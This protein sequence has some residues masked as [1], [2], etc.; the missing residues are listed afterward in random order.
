ME[1]FTKCNCDEVK[2]ILA[3]H[4]QQIRN[5]SIHHQLLTVRAARLV[6]RHN[7]TNKSADPQPSQS[8][9]T[10]RCNLDK[11][12]RP[13][14]FSLTSTVGRASATLGHIT[15]RARSVQ[16]TKD[17]QEEAEG[18]DRLLIIHQPKNETGCGPMKLVQPDSRRHVGLKVQAARL[19]SVFHDSPCQRTLPK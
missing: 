13:A 16:V 11:F 9:P 12:G 14:S 18:G 5:I 19:F 8:V 17:G 6:R 7:S 2:Q 4:K 1:L 3:A 10:R 15:H